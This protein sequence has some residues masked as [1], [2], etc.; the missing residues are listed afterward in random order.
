M[1]QFLESDTGG[2]TSS[3]WFQNLY[4]KSMPRYLDHDQLLLPW[5]VLGVGPL[6]SQKEVERVRRR[7]STVLNKVHHAWWINTQ[8]DIK[9]HQ[10]KTLTFKKERE[11][12]ERSCMNT[13][14]TIATIFPI[15]FHIKIVFY[16]YN[17]KKWSKEE[18]KSQSAWTLAFREIR[19]VWI[20]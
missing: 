3:S 7:R 20:S 1:S 4:A 2:E 19:I 5:F 9:R 11:W 17:F 15:W 16:Y 6:L 8:A 12:N 14:V 13:T 10:P 18:R